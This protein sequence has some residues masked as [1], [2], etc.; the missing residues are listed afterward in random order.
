MKFNLR[1]FTRHF[2]ILAAWK[3]HASRHNQGPFKPLGTMLQRYPRG[4]QEP[5]IGLIWCRET[6]ISQAAVRLIV[7]T[8][9]RW[10]DRFEKNSPARTSRKKCRSRASLPKQT[11]SAQAMRGSA[12]TNSSYYKRKK[13]YNYCFRFHFQRIFSEKCWHNVI[14]DIED[15]SIITRIKVYALELTVS[16]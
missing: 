10:K 15:I 1:K 2:C 6:P 13:P 12:N 8:S 16:V 14:V 9:R 4:F 3:V 7:G 11:S 5:L